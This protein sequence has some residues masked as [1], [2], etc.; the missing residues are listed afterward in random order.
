MAMILPPTSGAERRD[1]EKDVV[2]LLDICGSLSRAMADLSKRAVVRGLEMLQKGDRFNV[3]L[4]G[5]RPTSLSRKLLQASTQNI[6]EAVKFISSAEQRGGTD[7]YNAVIDGLEQFSSKRR[8]A[9]L[10]LVGDGRPTVGI[11]ETETIAA[12]VR[13][14]NRARARVFALAMG[15]RPDMALLDRIAVSAK[16][17]CVPVSGERQ[18]GPALGSFLPIMSAHTGSDLSLKVEGI[19]TERVLPKSVPDLQRS[20]A[21]I[22]VGRYDATSDAAAQVTLQGTAHKGPKPLT[23]TV[24][25]PEQEVSR[26]YILSIWAMRRVAELLER[27][28]A[29]G[30]DRVP[31][32]EM[33]DLSIRYGFSLPTETQLESPA[34]ATPLGTGN[35]D[36]LLWTLKRSFNPSDAEAQGVRRVHDK[37]FW[38]KDGRWIDT[39]AGN[40]MPSTSILFLSD[41]YFE[42]VRKDDQ[43]AK[44][45]AIGPTVTVE[46]HGTVF[47]VH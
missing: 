12:D 15:D 19:H 33:Q 24:T 22:L 44:Y 29:G 26:P 6:T 18:I 47:A 5:T 39:A 21:A 25:F 37:V 4:I 16:G 27:Q 28:I 17:K 43:L 38:W 13:K 2:F 9:V 45:F 42:Q 7:L 41:E 23:K 35:V 10:I 32:Q 46:H 3:V 8:Q 36:Y 11:C 14:F 1:L 40:G 30:P 31:N 34:S 20:D